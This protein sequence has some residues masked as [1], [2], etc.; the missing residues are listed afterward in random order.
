MVQIRF[1]N[2]WGELV[3]P[4]VTSVTYSV[5]LNGVEVG[6][7]YPSR[8]L[9]LEDPLSSYLF[10]LCSEGLSSLFKQESGTVK[11]ILQVHNPLNHG[12]YRCAITY[13][14]EQKGCVCVCSRQNVEE[15]PWM[16]KSYAEAIPTY[17]TG[18]FLLPMALCEELQRMMNSLWWGHGQQNR[19]GVIWQRWDKLCRSKDN[20]GMGFHNM[21]C[22]NLALPGDEHDGVLETLMVSDLLGHDGSVWDESKI[23]TIFQHTDALAILS[24]PIS[25]RR[26][27]DELIWHY[28]NNGIYDVKSGYHAAVEG[29]PSPEALSSLSSE[30][31]G[32]EEGVKE[33]RKSGSGSN[34]E[35]GNQ[36]EKESGV[37]K[38]ALAV[39][40]DE[41]AICKRT[42]AKY[43]L[44]SFTLDELEA[45]LQESG[46]EDNLPNVDDEIRS[47][48]WLVD[49]KIL[50]RFCA[51]VTRL[52]EELCAQLSVFLSSC[53]IKRRVVWFMRYAYVACCEGPNWSN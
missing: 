21:H 35:D 36:Q 25:S 34:V 9:R 12:R 42:R 48:L 11:N 23:F 1:A 39:D 10:I 24:I 33:K 14:K 8:G 37:R 27:N 30:V 40:D 50:F 15:D 5:C 17:T 47:L 6:P 46:D 4:C 53:L 29:M 28:R 19:Q 52:F 49:L 22:F 16:E 31:E 43:S 3:M 38:V 41:D 13:T 26:V 18:V 51:A 2:G 45:F 44:A 32:L 20:G 7:M